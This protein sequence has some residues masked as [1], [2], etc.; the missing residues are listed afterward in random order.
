[1][2]FF[3][4]SYLIEIFKNCHYKGNLGIKKEAYQL[5]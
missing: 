1:M 2:K 5:R 3:V 4:I